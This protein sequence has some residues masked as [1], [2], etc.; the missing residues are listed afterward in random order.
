M[1]GCAVSEPLPADASAA[2][3][4]GE[5]DAGT[6]APSA[7]LRIA[8]SSLAPRA[9]RTAAAAAPRL[10]GLP[11][12]ARAELAR[13]L[14][15]VRYQLARLGPAGIGGIGALIAAA[16]FALVM[17]VPQH[18]SLL[19]LRGELAGAGAPGGTGVGADSPDAMLAALPTRLQIP[20]V[21]GQVLVAANKAGVALDE[22]RYSY[23]PPRSGQLGRYAFEFPVK[24]PYPNIR[25]FIDRTL[26]AVPAAGL[27]KLHIERKDIGDPTTHADIG[28]VVFVRG[29]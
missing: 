22:G 4:G 16:V 9:A 17:I 29:D 23:R 6:A 5:A 20:A 18:E 14:P 24:A 1:A 28:F 21:L 25:D 26:V 7:P 11:V 8:P 2:P 19:A 10:A 13:V 27:D 15:G 12:R 3:P